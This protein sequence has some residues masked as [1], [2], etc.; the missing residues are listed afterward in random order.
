MNWEVVPGNFLSFEN[1]TST[2]LGVSETSRV[3]AGI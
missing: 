1:S 3:I 2:E